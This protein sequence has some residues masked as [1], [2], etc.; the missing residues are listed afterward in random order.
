MWIEKDLHA[1]SQI[2][3]AFNVGEREDVFQNQTHHIYH[4]NVSHMH[5]GNIP[6][7]Q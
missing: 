5:T 2:I 6:D 3:S 7:A 1:L 4:E